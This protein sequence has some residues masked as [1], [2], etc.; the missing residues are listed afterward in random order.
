MR[1]ILLF[2]LLLLPLGVC[3]QEENWGDTLSLPAA[4]QALLKDGKSWHYRKTEKVSE[5]LELLRVIVDTTYVNLTVHGDT[6]IDGQ[7]C[8]KMYWETA[9]TS[10]L[11]NIW[12]EDGMFVYIMDTEKDN[13]K[14]LVFNF[15]PQK[16]NHLTDWGQNWYL[17]T[18]DAIE[19]WGEYYNRY[20]YLSTN[21]SDDGPLLVDG[22]GTFNGIENRTGAVGGWNS[23]LFLGCYEG[24]EL[25][26]S[27]G[28]FFKVPTSLGAPETIM[29][30]SSRNSLYDLSGRK[31][32]SLQGGAGGRL[33]KGVYIQNGKKFVVK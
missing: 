15:T 10:F 20:H 5:D 30:E 12:L 19:C 16:G 9:D 17:N 28:D 24:E 31:L 23:F 6:I 3:A 7:K 2:A 32:P 25:I 22:I 13:M 4:H 1:R 18:I 21:G 33:H 11:H 14:N 26:F 27:R 8:W 29:Q